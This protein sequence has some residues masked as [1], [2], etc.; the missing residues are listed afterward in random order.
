MLHK[1]C[2]VFTPAGIAA[3]VTMNFLLF[4]MVLTYNSFIL[5]WWATADLTLQYISS[6]YL[7]IE[8]PYDPTMSLLSLFLKEMKSLPY[9]Y[10]HVHCSIKYIN[11][12]FE[13]NSVSIHG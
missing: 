6:K 2:K 7:K 11:Q 9:L 8:L 13:T 5:K 12:E 10:L 4:M 3:V 1:K